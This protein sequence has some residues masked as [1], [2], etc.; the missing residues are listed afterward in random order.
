MVNGSE[1]PASEAPAAFPPALR[2]TLRLVIVLNLSMFAIE[3]AVASLIGSV[4]LFAD[5]ADFLED[6]SLNLLVVVGLSWSARARSRLGGALA[7]V[8]LAP[9]LA[10]VVTAWVRL[11]VATPPAAGALGL[12]AAAALAVN[13]V[14]A[15]LL[16][17]HREVGG[18]LLRA[19][20]LSARNDT[21][22]NAAILA[23]A[24]LTSLTRA[25]WPDLVTGCVIGLLNA[26]AAWD[27]WQAARAERQT[28]GSPIAVGPP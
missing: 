15:G 18:S 16:V 1:P 3:A 2:A 17:R 7:G 25:T 23:A 13:S 8:L 28:S 5:C 24:G 26:G 27:V 10:T 22:A 19:A 4:S 14:C 9:T 20:F 6:A 11:E 12:T 21:L